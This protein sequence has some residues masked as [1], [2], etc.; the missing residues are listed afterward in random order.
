MGTVT[1]QKSEVLELAEKIIAMLS[2]HTSSMVKA[3]T[4]LRIADAIILAEWEREVGAQ[5]DQAI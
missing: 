1:G 4:A 3:S 2:E 5:S